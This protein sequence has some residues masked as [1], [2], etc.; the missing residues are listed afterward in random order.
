MARNYNLTIL[1]WLDILKTDYDSDN[2]SKKSFFL[3]KENY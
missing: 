1:I 2:E 3:S